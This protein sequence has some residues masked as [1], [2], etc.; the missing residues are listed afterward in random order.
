[1]K[2]L[3]LILTVLCE[4]VSI[5]A[6]KILFEYKNGNIQPSEQ[7][8]IYAAE[9]VYGKIDEAIQHPAVKY[10]FWIDK[11]ITHN[12]ADYKMIDSTS[13][14]TDDCYLY[15]I[16]FFQHK[17]EDES[18]LET[19][20]KD[21]IFSRLEI[22]CKTPAFNDNGK[23]IKKTNG[24]IEYSIEDEPFVFYNDGLWFRFYY[25]CLA[26]YS[27]SPKTVEDPTKAFFK[28]VR[29]T[30][31]CYAITLRGYRD[32]IDGTGLSVFVLYK[33]KAQLVYYNSSIDVNEIKEEGDKT[34]FVL[35][36]PKYD[37]NGKIIP[38]ISKMTFANGMISLEE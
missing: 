6:Q 36:T 18:D 32:S 10:P 24:K 12:S 26:P 34:T 22:V 1:M 11:E 5:S 2:K 30:K 37:D 4:S 3:F 38:V 16:K 14:I 13:L 27:D 20:G 31:D 23:P 35:Q 28:K 25:F 9:S 19:W 7:S 33:G 8:Y 21:N 29:L 15:E 17:N